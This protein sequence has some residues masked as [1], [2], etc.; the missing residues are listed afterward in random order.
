V[1]ACSVIADETVRQL[2]DQGRV[3]A[4]VEFELRDA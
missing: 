2:S 4:E 3:E 1:K